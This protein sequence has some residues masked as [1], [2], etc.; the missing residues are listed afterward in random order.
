MLIRKETRGKH[1]EDFWFI[2]LITLLIYLSARLLNLSSASMAEPGW[3]QERKNQR[4][5]IKLKLLCLAQN[6]NKLYI[7]QIQTIYKN[8]AVATFWS[9]CLPVKYHV[10]DR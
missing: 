5:N 7:I 2:P 6:L 9:D 3:D 10:I 4:R 8:L 1:H